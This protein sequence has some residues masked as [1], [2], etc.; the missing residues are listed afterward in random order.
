ACACPGGSLNCGAAPGTCAT[1]PTAPLDGSAACASDGGPS[2]VATCSNPNPTF[3]PGPNACVN[4]NT[5]PNNCGNCDA[6]CQT[7]LEGGTATCNASACGGSCPMNFMLC[8][9]SGSFGC[10][11]PMHD[12]N[13]CR[14]CGTSC[15]SSDAGVCDAGTCM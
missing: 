6:G 15:A 11:D 5:D 9:D 10:A 4:T 12:P 3:C 1:C 8:I 13:N 2:C 7:P 14:T